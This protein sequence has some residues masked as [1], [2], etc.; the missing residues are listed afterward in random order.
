MQLQ[1]TA[2][3][4]GLCF[5]AQSLLLSEWFGRS[6]W[7]YCW[8][9]LWCLSFMETNTYCLPMAHLSQDRW[10][11]ALYKPF[12]ICHVP[13]LLLPYS[14]LRQGSKE[15]SWPFKHK[16]GEC[17][18]QTEQ[19]AARSLHVVTVVH[20]QGTLHFKCANC[21]YLPEWSQWG[22]SCY[23]VLPKWDTSFSTFSGSV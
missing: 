6:G 2:I 11:L 16:P 19:L 23:T 4:L 17:T 21:F 5:H 13:C 3:P 14:I 7:F 10:M 15:R 9:L 8:K 12:G 1:L 20:P 22:P 18:H